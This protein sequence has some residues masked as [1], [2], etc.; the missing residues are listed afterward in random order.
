[1]AGITS[2]VGPAIT[3]LLQDKTTEEER[4]KNFFYSSHMH[5]S[6]GLKWLQQTTTPL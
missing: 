5:E 6:I 2:L 3:L 4:I 1:M